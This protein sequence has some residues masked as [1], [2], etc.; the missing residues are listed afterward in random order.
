MKTILWIW[1]SWALWS[2]PFL[3]FL[4]KGKRWRW[5]GIS[6]FLGLSFSQLW[7]L[8][9]A[10]WAD[11]MDRQPPAVQRASLASP[12]SGQCWQALSKHAEELEQAPATTEFAVPG[13]S[14]V[15]PPCWT[16]A[17]QCLPV[18]LWS[19]F[20]AELKRSKGRQRI[21]PGGILFSLSEQVRLRVA[22]LYSWT[23]W[24][25]TWPRYSAWWK[26]ILRKTWKDEA[27]LSCLSEEHVGLRISFSIV[28]ELIFLGVRI[29]VALEAEQERSSSEQDMGIASVA[30]SMLV[31]D[32]CVEN[33]RAM[34]WGLE[35]GALLARMQPGGGAAIPPPH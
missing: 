30:L 7:F 9:S 25:S 1:G 19:V 21:R 27:C 20:H 32:V 22:S 10:E 35:A 4:C 2:W 33:W 3:I 6:V 24:S 34:H 18:L 11:S 8:P 12:D 16:T 17:A 29:V 26:E 14:L 5:E 31:S 23:N 28:I 15:W 13:G